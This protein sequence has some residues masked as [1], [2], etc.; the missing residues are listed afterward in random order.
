MKSVNCLRHFWDEPAWVTVALTTH[1]P[2]LITTGISCY[3]YGAYESPRHKE[4]TSTLEFKSADTAPR[5]LIKHKAKWSILTTY[6][7]LKP[8]QLTLRYQIG[9]YDPSPFTAGGFL[10]TERRPEWSYPHSSV[11]C[12]N[13]K[14]MELCLHSPPYSLMSTEIYK[15]NGKSYGD[16]RCVA[17]VRLDGGRSFESHTGHACRSAV[18]CIVTTCVGK[19]LATEGS[20]V[21]RVLRSIKEFV[22]SD[23]ILNGTE[24]ITRDSVT[25]K[26]SL[27]S[28]CATFYKIQSR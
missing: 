18:F 20:S 28:I 4:N 21:Q 19:D 8:G 23:V 10:P 22:V 14:W 25:L 3:L 6:K 12:Q 1:M 17:L 9:F 13:V 24:S 27:V 2:V 7:I 16:T 26:S 15:C 5:E 11:Y